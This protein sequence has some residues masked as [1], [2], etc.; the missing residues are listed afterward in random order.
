MFHALL[1]SALL[2]HTTAACRSTSS[3]AL[4]GDEH[5]ASL[6]PLSY[7]SCA[8]PAVASVTVGTP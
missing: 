3:R 8:S 1:S 5:K 2:E 6:L 7:P 4:F